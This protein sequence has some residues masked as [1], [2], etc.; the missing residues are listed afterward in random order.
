[1]ST[2]CYCIELRA[3]ARKTSA[4]YDEALAPFGI[5]IAQYSLLRKIDRAKRISL[6][7][8]ASISDLDRS[9]IGRNAKVLERMGLV[10]SV[11]GKDQREALL[12][13]STMGQKVLADSIPAHAAAQAKIEDHLGGP[14]GAKDLLSRLHSL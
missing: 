1:M 7:E 2:L 11:S 4:I 6:T 14:E 12:E 5:T 3:A 10:Q 13:L 9:T 8:L